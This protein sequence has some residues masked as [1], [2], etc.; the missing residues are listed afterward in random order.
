MF[1]DDHHELREGGEGH[2]G[3]KAGSRGMCKHVDISDTFPTHVS[4]A[5][6][7]SFILHERILMCSETLRPQI[8]EGLLQR[9]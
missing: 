3:G 8:T 6:R 1:A 2:E 5:T 4:S 7:R 9:V